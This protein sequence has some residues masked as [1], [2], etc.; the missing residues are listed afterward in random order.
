MAARH[1]HG[2]FRRSTVSQVERLQF[3][4]VF[5]G[6]GGA[7]PGCCHHWEEDMRGRYFAVLMAAAALGACA[8]AEEKPVVAQPPVGVGAI[9]GTVA[10]DRD[11]NGEPDGWY[12]ADGVYHAFQFPPC[13][14]PPP[15]PPP[16]PK[17]ERG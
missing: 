17:G 13:P 11:G 7:T 3:T 15:P 12:T 10:A 16:S 1:R 6:V 8:T 4:I 14:P 5:S 2:T 9:V